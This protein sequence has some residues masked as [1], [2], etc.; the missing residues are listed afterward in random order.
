MKLFDFFFRAAEYGVILPGAFLCLIPVAD[1]LVIP[2]RKLYPVLVPVLVAICFLLSWLDTTGDYYTNLFFFPLLGVCL[3]AYFLMVRLE[4]LKLVYMFVCTTAALSFGCILNYY[5][6]AQLVPD[7]NIDDNSIPGL[8]LQ[9]T[10]SLVTM[11][12][13]LAMRRKFR[14][15]FENFNAPSFWRI[16]WLMPAVITFCNIYMI[17]ID[18]NNIRVGRVF[19]IAMVIEGVLFLFFLLFQ[20]LLYTIAVTS[21]EK[22]EASTTALMYQLQADQY[23]K[24]QTYLD[25][26]RRIRHDFK[27]TIAVL[28]ELSQ[29]GQFDK[30][31][32]Y[33]SN[34]SS[35][36]ANV[37]APVVY[38]ENPVVNATINYY[39]ELAKS[40]GIQTKLLVTLPA[41]LSIS[42]IDL[43]LIFGNLLEN[44]VTACRQVKHDSRFI[45]LS[46]DLSTPGCL[47]ITMV[48]SFSGEVHKQNG[49]YMSTKKE[50]SGIGLTSIQATTQKHQGSCSFYTE[51][52]TF[53]SNVM[54]KL[55]TGSPDNDSIRQAGSVHTR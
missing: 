53:I 11:G 29:T 23:E 2:P 51:A 24:M 18:Y 21:A 3:I 8:I 9:Y 19:Q 37:Q 52:D 25:E 40:Y 14:W 34:Y 49:K 13:L 17:P 55:Q 6:I 54:L 38:C 43:C 47:Y 22:I 46:A 35:E 15:L 41:E 31:S 27:H 39:I 20:F 33:I 28:N 44:A 10:V 36:I 45:R 48:N 32:D 7:S 16:A 26:T 30:L 5:V 4:K 1:W 12:I 42:D 50:K